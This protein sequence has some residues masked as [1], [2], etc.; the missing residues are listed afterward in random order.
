ML[1]LLLAIIYLAFIS[2]GLPDS[3]LGS[4]WPVMHQELGAPLAAMGVI[5]MIIASGTIVSSLFSTRLIRRFGTG[6]VT[7][8]SV[9]LTAFALLGFSWSRSMVQLGLWSLPYGLGAGAVDAALNNYVALHYA[10]RHMSWL[11]AFW[12]VGVTISPNI[13]SLALTQHWGWQRG[14]QIVALL[15]A[16]LTTVLVISL[17]LWR[18]KKTRK[19]QELPRRLSLKQAWQI[20]GVPFVMVSF[21][22]FCA[23]ESTA[24]LW[25]SSYLVGARQINADMA[26]SFT[27]LF[28]LGETVGRFLTGF[29]AD[30][31]GDHKMVRLGIWIMIAGVMLVILPVAT[32]LFSL[33]GL[34]VIGLGAAPVYPCLI[35]STPTNFGRENSQ[36]LVGIQ[37]ASAYIGSTFMPP[38]FGLLAQHVTVALYPYFL[39]IF[40]LLMLIMTIGLNRVLHKKSTR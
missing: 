25:A 29:I 13:M 6:V 32:P 31:F 5:S 8:F 39:G 16:I 34:V 36:A 33:I 12:G 28:Y 22:A 26:A 37:M 17:P 23:L 9:G 18:Q 3:L 19:D 15:Q 20:N 21:M 27:A 11:H 14:Y 35:H 1:S 40:A 38:L 4:A 2:L 30:R 7:A 10:S 24:G